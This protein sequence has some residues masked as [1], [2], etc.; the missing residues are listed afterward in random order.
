[1]IT[2][3]DGFRFGSEL[4]HSQ[5]HVDDGYDNLTAPPLLDPVVTLPSR[6]SGSFPAVPKSKK[7]SPPP[8][9]P[10]AQEDKP[11]ITTNPAGDSGNSL[12]LIIVIAAA[13]FFL[14]LLAVLFI[15]FRSRTTRII[16]WKTGLSG[17]LQKA[18]VTGVPKLNIPELETTCE[19][20]SNIIST[21][22]GVATLYKGT[23]SS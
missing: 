20:F 7:P 10:V 23:L 2:A 6:S 22:V 12:M 17:Q 11:L 1:M 21:H 14:I 4:S 16:P 19:D 3:Q 13:I 15:I 18:F 9:T 8:P 5:I